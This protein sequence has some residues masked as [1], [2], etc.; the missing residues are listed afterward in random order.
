MV[1]LRMKT[2]RSRRDISH[3]CVRADWHRM[4]EAWEEFEME[5]SMQRT[6]RVLVSMAVLMSLFVWPASGQAA[7]VTADIGGYWWRAT[8]PLQSGATVTSYIETSGDIDWLYF[9]VN[10]TS[11]VSMTYTGP[12]F[13]WGQT[14]VAQVYRYTNGSL[15][16]LTNV[17][18]GF[19]QQFEPGLYCVAV[20]EAVGEY[21]ATQPYTLTVTGA[22][23]QM[24]PGSG[25]PAYPAS[26]NYSE[27]VEDCWLDAQGPLAR[28]RVN[29]GLIGTAG[30]LDWY[31]FHVSAT[32]AVQVGVSARDFGWGSSYKAD[33]YKYVNGSMEHVRGIGGPWDGFSQEL[34]AG[35]YYVRV[36]AESSGDYSTTVPYSLVVRGAK[37]SASPA[38]GQ[39]KHPARK[40]HAE[41][42]E[43]S[44]LEA[45][46]PLS[47][48]TAHVGWIGTEGDS[49]WYLFRTAAT[50][51]VAVGITDPD[52]GW[53]SSYRADIY[54]LS[55]GELED[56]DRVSGPWGSMSVELPAGTYYV[57]V[58]S[59]SSGDY[60]TTHPYTLVVQGQSVATRRV[61]GADRY[62]TAVQASKANFAGGASTVILATGADYPDALAASGLAGS[63][64]A[65]LLL[66]T[67]G[68]LPTTVRD[69]IK[70]L[71]ATKVIIV[72]GTG[73]VSDGVKRA[74][75][76]IPGVSVERIA[77]ANRYATAAAIA[78]R[79]KTRA[80]SAF[81]KK[82]FV[83]TGT[84]F[85]D[86]LA[87]SP[88]AY[89]KKIPILL[90]Q[91][92]VAT[93]ATVNAIDSLGIQSVVIAGGTGAV[94]DGVKS[95]LGVP[96]A[97]V[98]G[99]DRYATSAA[100]A[101]YCATKGW[102]G[103]KFV[104]LATGA[105]FPDALGGGVSTGRNG[106]VLLLTQPGTLPSA[107]KAKISANRSAIR[108]VQIYGGT[109]AVAEPVI[110]TLCDQLPRY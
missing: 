8:G 13:G 26:Q 49:D 17:G 86:A 85:A 10:E 76:A 51:P 32:G 68:A 88:A 40:E 41:L 29:L 18:D 73:A 93:Q 48:S 67:R 37:V 64:A 58:K 74:V 24:Q 15:D 90:T 103:F 69:E 101:A 6:V 98:S 82:A 108:W 4:A 50:Y 62:A 12:N 30:D 19:S 61:A 71:R 46:G 87:V 3:M 1:A 9:Y 109:G 99:A 31:Y 94:S 95:R 42:T 60:S 23:V 20:Y 56:V 66:T 57:E 16:Y 75:D 70:R 97:R 47:R 55:N 81:S 107:A 77:G 52:F 54:R 89:A 53:G 36:R 25:V 21:S 110:K 104:G 39:P 105:G 34:E 78:A 45:G 11:A 38:A 91:P 96:A 33:V 102:V 92:T 28:D 72:G 83:V 106:G 7:T 35:L 59:E 79:V 22:A 2:P 84:S 27:V 80:G 14:Y 100:V 5:G 63:Y 44:Y 43:E 65:P